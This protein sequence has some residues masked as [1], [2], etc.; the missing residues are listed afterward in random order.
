[1][2]VVSWFE[3]A[4]SSLL[5]GICAQIIGYAKVWIAAGGVG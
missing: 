5:G 1:M 2:A 4:R 3:G